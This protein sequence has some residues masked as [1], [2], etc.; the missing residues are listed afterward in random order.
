V[1]LTNE[2]ILAQYLQVIVPCGSTSLL[3]ICK[4]V[5]TE[6]NMNALSYLNFQNISCYI[7]W[8]QSLTRL[9]VYYELIMKHCIGTGTG[10]VSNREITNLKYLCSKM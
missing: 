3:G 1:S 10:S 2:N 7:Y 4:Q 9:C 5:M 8:K 6:S